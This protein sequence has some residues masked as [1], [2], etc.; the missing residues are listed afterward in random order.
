MIV[1]NNKTL[2]RNET[3]E[4]MPTHVPNE[5]RCVNDDFV[6]GFSRNDLLNEMRDN[7]L[8][9]PPSETFPVRPRA[10]QSGGSTLFWTERQQQYSVDQ[11]V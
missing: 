11:S 10:E 2:D 6:Q 4:L 3:S 5:T 7:I 1:A 9:L 8:E